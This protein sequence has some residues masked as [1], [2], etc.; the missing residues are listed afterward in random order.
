MFAELL[1]LEP[2]FEGTLYATDFS[3]TK[4]AKVV[5]SFIINRGLSNGPF[6]NPQVV[7]HV[8]DPCVDTIDDKLSKADTYQTDS[9]MELIAYISSN[10]MF[11]E[12]VWKPKLL[13][14]LGAQDSIAPFQKIWVVDLQKDKIALEWSDG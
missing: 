6:F 14:F 1:K 11:P 3:D 5:G 7:G 9:P 2:G 8:G 10:P 4:L 12:N 13:D